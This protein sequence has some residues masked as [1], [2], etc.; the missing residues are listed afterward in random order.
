MR[1]WRRANP[2]KSRLIDQRRVEKNPKRKSEYY[3]K[4][5]EKSNA[6]TN[7][8]RRENPEKSYDISISNQS[9]RRSAKAL[10]AENYTLAEIRA[11]RKKYGKKCAFCQATGRLTIDHI[12]PL[13]RGGG[14][15]IRNIQFLCKPCNSKKHAKDPIHFAQELGMLL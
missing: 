14:N 8:W 7:K 4:N 6:A 12:V 1:E 13:A 11:L 3:A 5:K 2:E 15:G 9:K 10:S